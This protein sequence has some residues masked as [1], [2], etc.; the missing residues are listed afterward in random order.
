MPPQI[1][2][3][4]VTEGLQRARYLTTPRVHTV[5][6]LAFGY[7][8]SNGNYTPHATS[9]IT[10]TDSLRVQ[11]SALSTYLGGLGPASSSMILVGHSQGGLV[12]R[13]TTRTD[14]VLGVLTIGSPHDGAP[15]VTAAASIEVYLAL[16]DVDFYIAWD[17]LQDEADCDPIDDP[18][19]NWV[20]AALDYLAPGTTLGMVAL[21]LGDAYASW[22]YT[23]LAQLAP[24]SA[25][26]DTLEVSYAH[27][28]AAIRSSITV[29]DGDEDAGPFRLVYPPYPAASPNADD[30]A[31]ALF[32]YGIN[33]AYDGL[34]IEVLDD[35]DTDY[36]YLEHQEAGF[37][38]EEAGAFIGDFS[39]YWNYW[40]SGGW[41]ND[42][43]VPTPNQTMPNSTYTFAITSGVSHTEETIQYLVITGRL[44]Q[45][46]GR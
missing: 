4:M 2:P 35:Y 3:A 31:A 6:Y 34:A 15:L 40:V 24:G 10:W 9:A 22:R 17:G 44:N 1:T 39:Y 37:A 11:A 30:Y 13:L 46:T 8:T 21:G 43:V 20:P 32:Y 5:L 29:D 12:S 41:P 25:A 45:M 36:N 28:K 23:D 14:S 27:E 19:C 18:I 26:I 38:L 42:G 16:L 7:L 33:M